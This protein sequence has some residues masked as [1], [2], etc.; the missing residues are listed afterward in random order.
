LI[1]GEA[2]IGANTCR[3]ILT[4]MSDI[5]DRR[6]KAYEE[7]LGKARDA[8]TEAMIRR[9]VAINANAVLAVDLD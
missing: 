3:D 7:A 6:S 4:S 1:N 8:A 5:V 9:A 2:I